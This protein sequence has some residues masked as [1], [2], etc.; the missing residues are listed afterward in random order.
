MTEVAPATPETPWRGA[1][2]PWMRYFRPPRLRSPDDTIEARNFWITAWGFLVVVVVMLGAMSAL[3]PTSLKRHA[4]TTAAVAALVALLHEV[5]RRGRTRLASWM[6]VVGLVVVVTQRAWG[7]GGIYAPVSVFYVLFV[8][9]AGGLLGTMASVTVTVLCTGGAAVLLFA[10]RGGEL[11]PAASSPPAAALL[12]VVVSLGLA[13]VVESLYFRSLR[14]RLDRARTQLVEERR[15]ELQ[16]RDDLVAMIVHDMRSPLTGLSASLE[17]MRLDAAVQLHA[18][19]DGALD[20]AKSLNRLAT[21]LVDVVRFEEGRMPV[22]LRRTELCQLVAAAQ[23]NLAGMAAAHTVR[24]SGRPPVMAECDPEL[25]RRVIENLLS[26]AIK[27]T[28]EGGTVRIAV[29]ASLGWARVEVHDEGPG[30]PEH[31]R[32]QIFEK[33]GTV[34]ANG[35][36]HSVGL[37]LAF[38]KFAVEAHNGTIGVTDDTPRGSVFAFEIPVDRGQ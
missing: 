21:S 1:A 31:L 27:H 26:N 38:C 4:V 15:R 23:T 32:K 19:I 9:M 25:I 33:F 5:N 7:T 28:A 16:M 22:A 2:Q 6:F 18:V 13:V 29:T 8:L 36:Y 3:D 11:P 30:V 10:H 17:L 14:A 12:F 35:A 20:S 37:G 34:A 24:V